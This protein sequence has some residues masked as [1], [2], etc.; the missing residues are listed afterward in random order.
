MASDHKKISIKQYPR[1]AARETAEDRYWQKLKV[2]IIV[3]E[4]APITDINFSPVAPHEFAVTSSTRVQIYSSVTN[5]IVKTISRFTDVAYGGSFRDDGKLLVAG[6]ADGGVQVFDMNSRIILRHFKGH[7]RACHVSRFAHRDFTRVFSAGDDATVRVWDIPTEQELACFRGHE[8]YIRAGV[9]TPHDPKLFLTGSYDHT[10]RLWD[11]R[12][13]EGT[14]AGQVLSLDHGDPVESVLCFP[15]GSLVVS[16][17]GNTIKVWDILAGNKV[18]AAFS[19]HQKTITS[20]CFDSEHKRLLSASLDRQIKVYDVTNWKVVHSIKESAPILSMGLA[21][22]DTHLVVGM[23]TGL[24]SIKHRQATKESGAVGAGGSAGGPRPRPAPRSGTYRFYI[25]GQ[26]NKGSDVDFKVEVAKKKALKSYDKL[27]KKFKYSE[28]LDAVLSDKFRP[29]VV[30]SL[31]HE[32]VQREGL[33]IAL[34]GRDDQALKPVLEFVCKNI[35]N[36]RYTALLVAVSDVIL[37]IYAPSMGQSPLI[38][39][40]FVKLKQRV[41]MELDF[42][43]KLFQTLGAMETILAGGNTN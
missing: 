41:K 8:D 42:Q 4:H 24:L 9:P 16:A 17:G 34:S 36:P 2:P 18:L 37:D 38:D 10:V 30:V 40:L 25:R 43:E 20:L 29:V 11:S 7:T 23:A 5:Q 6:C 32:L 26:N 39:D 13:P 15:S 28:A 19:N 3:K 22:G 35:A 21:P 27:L 12:T 31:L 1:L 14:G 33:Q